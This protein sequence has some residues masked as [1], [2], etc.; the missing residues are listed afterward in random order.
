[1]NEGAARV[2]KSRSA[3]GLQLTP[4]ESSYLQVADLLIISIIYANCGGETGLN[5][6]S[7]ISHL[8]RAVNC[9]RRVM[10]ISLDFARQFPKLLS[11]QKARKRGW[12]VLGAKKH[13]GAVVGTLYLRSAR[14]LMWYIAASGP[15]KGEG[16]K[17]VL[18][19]ISNNMYATTLIAYTYSRAWACVQGQ[20]NSHCGEPPRLSG[21]KWISHCVPRTP[22]NKDCI[23]YSIGGCGSGGSPTLCKLLVPTS[24]LSR[25]DEQSRPFFN[26]PRYAFSAPWKIAEFFARRSP[27]TADAFEEKRHVRDLLIF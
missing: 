22:G 12:R 14:R 27:S 15:R 17:I 5:I 26:L 18:A 20:V 8:W 7:I 2:T 6:A 23:N 19:I 21:A 24:T 9:S 25:A 3:R 11:R 10:S 1:M 16:K 13:L 4:D